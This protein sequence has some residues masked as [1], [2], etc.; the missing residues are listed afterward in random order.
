MC[1]CDWTNRIVHDAS[2]SDHQEWFQDIISVGCECCS[3]LIHHYCVLDN[4]ARV[5]IRE[6]LTFQSCI[7]E[8]IS[9]NSLYRTYLLL[10]VLK[11][12]LLKTENSVSIAAKPQTEVDVNGSGSEAGMKNI[13]RTKSAPRNINSTTA[14]PVLTSTASSKGNALDN[15]NI[16]TQ[17]IKAKKGSNRL[18]L[19]QSQ[20]NILGSLTST[21]STPGVNNL[22]CIIEEICKSGAIKTICW[23]LLHSF[24]SIRL[25]SCDVCVFD[26]DFTNL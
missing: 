23:C 14:I 17:S 8:L 10:L 9:C 5:D 24:K 13:Q 2:A 25:I 12:Y 1:R 21:D 3:Y 4:N 15:R 26:Y 22:S 18:F 16:K 19:S 6:V 7:Q 11:C 20:G